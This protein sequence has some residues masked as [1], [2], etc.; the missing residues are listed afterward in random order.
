MIRP[1]CLP[2]PEVTSSNQSS[3]RMISNPAQLVKKE[4]IRRVTDSPRSPSPLQSGMK[5]VSSPVASIHMS[6]QLSPRS[7]VHSIDKAPIVQKGVP[8]HVFEEVSRK[9]KFLEGRI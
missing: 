1:P 2:H 4:P 7:S 6:R 3:R 9:V 5:I 8:V